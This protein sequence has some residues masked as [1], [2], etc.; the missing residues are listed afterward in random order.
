MLVI[1]KEEKINHVDV[2][3]KTISKA[4]TKD[5]SGY[6]S[7]S[8]V[9]IKSKNKKVNGVWHYNCICPLCGETF[10]ALP[11]KVINGNNTSCG[12]AVSSS[13]EIIIVSI[14]NELNLKYERQKG[15]ADCK[16]KYTLPFD[17]AVYDNNKLKCLIKYDGK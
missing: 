16:Y 1:Y 6:V 11:I 5:Y 3:G 2:C 9:V 14:L 12:C 10:I 8:G 4:N 13:G 7:A 17:F 15:F